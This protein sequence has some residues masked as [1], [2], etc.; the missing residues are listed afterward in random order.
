MTACPHDGIRV[1][2]NLSVPQI[3]CS[4]FF[5]QQNQFIALSMA[6]GMTNVTL[7]TTVPKCDWEMSV[8]QINDMHRV[9]STS[10]DFNRR[11]WMPLILKSS[12]MYNIL[13]LFI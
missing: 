13:I 5:G 6:K 8:L 11:N 7:A 10:F 3:M 9:R 4:Q 2:S 1:V 12:C